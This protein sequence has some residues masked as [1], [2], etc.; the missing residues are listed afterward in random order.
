MEWRPLLFYIYTIGCISDEDSV[1]WDSQE[2]EG[3]RMI[4]IRSVVSNTL[5]YRTNGASESYSR[6]KCTLYYT[7]NIHCQTLWAMSISEN[8]RVPL[9]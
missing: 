2:T 8:K 3:L 4:Q 7:L 5:R 1:R 6:Q 9:D